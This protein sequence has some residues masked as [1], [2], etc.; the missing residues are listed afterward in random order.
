MEQ[1]RDGINPSRQGT[2]SNHFRFWISEGLGNKEY[3]LKYVLNAPS[4]FTVTKLATL[5][6]VKMRVLHTS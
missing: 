1:E 5:V 3:E 6:D 2:T 4:L